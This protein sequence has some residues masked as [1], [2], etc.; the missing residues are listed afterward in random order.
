MHIFSSFQT[1]KKPIVNRFFWRK[2]ITL[3]PLLLIMPAVSL[4][5]TSLTLSEAIQLSFANHSELRAFSYRRA[6]ADGMAQQARVGS[7]PQLDLSVE[8]ALGSGDYSGADSLQSTL[9]ISWVLEGDLLQQ[10]GHSVDVQKRVIS[11]EQ[12]IK[13]LDVAAETA[14][15]FLTVVVYQ[16][17]KALA[18]AA[19]AQAESVAK[20]LSKRMDAGKSLLADKL[21]AEAELARADIALEDLDHEIRGAKRMLAT[22]WNAR[23]TDFD[24]ASGSLA[25]A[26]EKLDYEALAQQLSSHPRVQKL[27][28]QERVAQSEI[29]L[30]KTEAQSRWQF[31]TGV[32]RFENT[33]DYALVAGFTVPLGGEQRNSGR[34]AA[35]AAERDRYRADADAMQIV[36]EARLYVLLQEFQHAQHVV[37]AL[38]EQI[39]PRLEKAQSEARNAYQ[40]GRYSYQD[41]R[42]VQQELLATRSYLLDSQFKAQLTRVEIERLS[43]LP[44]LGSDEVNP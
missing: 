32:R 27:L 3:L 14:R 33:D 4:A 30:A 35:L 42:G 44:L 43:G 13:K 22:Q 8:D 36:L 21:R 34:I 12:A 38:R 15:Q 16:Q 6:A 26:A 19:R 9:S 40:L 1:P 7:R 41:W 17:R 29:A 11:D 18:E 31:S 5:E 25:I 39:L 37:G 10:R 2:A 28:S 20:E 24:I 23:Q